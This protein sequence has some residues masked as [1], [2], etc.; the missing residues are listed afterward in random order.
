MRPIEA[1]AISA[2]R[3]LSADT[4]QKANSG[5]PG[6]PIGA[7][8]AAYAI[9]SDMRHDPKH[10]T[11]PGRDRFVLSS[12]HASS[13][14]Y[15]MLHLYGYGLTIEDMQQFRQYGSLTP[16]HPEYGH[17]VGVEATTG[18]LGQG[19]AM[20][21][22][23]AMAEA[24]MA[25][26]FNRDGF[27]VVDNYTYV[28]MGDGCMMEGA[29]Y[30]AASLAGTQKLNKLIAV[31]DSNRITIEGSTDIAFTENV[32]ARFS[33]MGWQ[34]INVENGED[35]VAISLALEE[36]RIET[37]RPSLIIVRTDIAH[38]TMKEG[39]AA[40]HGSPLGDDVIADM[41]KRLGWKNAPFDIPED[42]Y[43]HFEA[44]ALRGQRARKEYEEMYASYSEAYPELAAQLEDWRSGKISEDVFTDDAMLAADAPKA[45]RSSSG[46]VLNR[47]FAHMPNMFGG[48]ADLGPSN[49]TELK[50]SGY[51]APD[52]REGCNIHFG[53]RELAM[54]CIANGITLYG[55]LRAFCATFFVFSDYVKPALR[56]SALMKLPVTYVLTHD[57][58]GVGEDGPTH[59]PIEH[60]A[61]L[62]ATPNTYVFRPADQKETA[63]AYRAALKLK[64]PSVMALS[65]QNLPQLED[66]SDKAMLGG[67]ILREPKGTPDVILMASG[68]EVELMYKAADILSVQGYT[69]RLVSMPCMEL[70][71]E[72]SEE[73]KQSVL[74]SSIRARVS[75]EAGAT[76]PWGMFVGLDGASIGLDHFGASAKGGVLFKEFGFT[77]ENVAATA[78]DVIKRNR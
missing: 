49:N 65:R 40:A 47:L 62:R 43:A 17:T 67:Y 12:G 8:P 29:S 36:A 63:Y 70:F 48:S 30:E 46:V 19:F 11:W 78:L 28:L 9:W 44:L 31:Y 33:A 39:S 23:M 38:G 5:H 34:V 77:A 37:E 58:I 60:L 16:G 3:V 71:N 53:V 74:P 6:M 45:T 72:Q 42:V 56:L 68:S 66:T 10:P 75:I 18:P 20:A 35:I 76:Q 50:T 7:A 2:I 21:V 64:A 59:Q 24:H 61:A 73:Y 14:L 1:K 69:A 26:I 13:L 55:G 32:G 41:R 25:A 15:S 52:C 22:G 54:A 51:F 27:K 57:S 4:V